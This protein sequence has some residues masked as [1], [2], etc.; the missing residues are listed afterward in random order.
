MDKKF[1]LKVYF[2]DKTVTFF[3]IQDAIVNPSLPNL[4][5]VRRDDRMIAGFVLDKVDFWEITDEEVS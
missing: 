1:D 4:L 3:G 5:F 2:P